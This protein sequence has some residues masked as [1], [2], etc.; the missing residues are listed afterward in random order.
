MNFSNLSI[1]CSDF[2]NKSFL[3]QKSSLE[4]QSQ[5]E[6]IR[7]LK[8]SSQEN[9]I[10]MNKNIPYFEITGTKKLLKHEF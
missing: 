6:K 4:N 7:G 5:A 8:F 10:S 9:A 2:E 1:A 3:C